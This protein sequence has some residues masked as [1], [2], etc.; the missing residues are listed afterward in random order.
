MYQY[1]M[2]HAIWK[3]FLDLKL[4]CQ[5]LLH[6]FEV[7]ISTQGLTG[8]LKHIDVIELPRWAPILAQE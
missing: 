8:E 5:I 2:L 6:R 4:I 3:T 1:A 7:Q